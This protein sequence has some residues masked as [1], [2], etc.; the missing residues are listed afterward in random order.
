MFKSHTRELSLSV[1]GLSLLA[2]CASPMLSHRVTDEDRKKPSEGVHYYLTKSKVIIPVAIKLQKCEA[3]AVPIVQAVIADP[4]VSPVKDAEYEFRVTPKDAWGVFRAIDNAS[5]TLTDDRRLAK[6]ET[7][8]TDKTL[9]TLAAL[10]KAAIAGPVGA[11]T[12]AAVA[13]NS[14]STPRLEPVQLDCKDVMNSLLAD[15]TKLG[16]AL[17]SLQKKEIEYL[18][19]KSKEVDPRDVSRTLAS[20]AAAKKRTLEQIAEVKKALTVSDAIELE[21]ATP[22][23]Q[24][25]GCSDG[26]CGTTPLDISD[27][28]KG[29]TSVKFNPTAKMISSSNTPLLGVPEIS[30]LVQRAAS[31]SGIVYRQD[32]IGTVT[33]TFASADSG[34][35]FLIKFEKESSRI[36]ESEVSPFLQWGRWAFLPMDVGLLSSNSVAVTFDEWGVPKTASWSA[37]PVGLLEILNLYHAAVPTPK[38]VQSQAAPSQTEVDRAAILKKLLEICKDASSEAI[39]DFCTAILK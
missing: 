33:T 26:Y 34:G 20:F 6:A 36:K 16:K 28:F 15:E 27:W 5:L 10:A 25:A 22:T 2:G 39:P 9:E 1:L 24:V 31:T 19:S 35:K 37:Q 29:G 8:T 12:Q 17:V 32:G 11:I 18:D 7:K 14:D 30:A 38:P 23:K 4:V 13:L 21:L 3:G